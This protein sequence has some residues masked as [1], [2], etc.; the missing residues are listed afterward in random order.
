MHLRCRGRVGLKQ[1]LTRV[2]DAGV[3]QS[4][5][6]Q[7]NVWNH[8]GLPPTTDRVGTR[9]R[10]AGVLSHRRSR[11]PR[12]LCQ[13]PGRHG[14]RRAGLGDRPASTQCNP[15][16]ISQLCS[17]S[18]T[19]AAPFS[20]AMPRSRTLHAHARKRGL[21][22]LAVRD[23][24]VYFHHRGHVDDAER[25]GLPDGIGDSLLRYVVGLRQCG[26]QRFSVGGREFGHHVCAPTSRVRVARV[27]GARRSAVQTVGVSARLGT[28]RIRRKARASQK[29]GT[30]GGGPRQAA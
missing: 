2:T 1:A 18:E 22:S 11:R 25:C 20:R 17:I 13:E 21:I 12:E 6:A 7:S 10:L 28:G 5:T 30:R 19:P 8:V 4:N 23:E 15:H 14:T 24:D 16:L 9:T 29:N 3:S 26:Q 27:S